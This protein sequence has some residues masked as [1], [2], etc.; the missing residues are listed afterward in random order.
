VHQHGIHFYRDHPLGPFQQGLGQR[1]APRADFD[2][3]TRTFAASRVRD[4]IQN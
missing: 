1:P 4:A 3:G 2:H